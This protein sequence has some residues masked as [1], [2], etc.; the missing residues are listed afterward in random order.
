[1]EAAVLEGCKSS[2]SYRY[3]AKVNSLLW[4]LYFS[5]EKTSRP[6]VI[7]WWLLEIRNH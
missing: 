6:T 4:S 3:A 2:L 5:R 1:M 7:H